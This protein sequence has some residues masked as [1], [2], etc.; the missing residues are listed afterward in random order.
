MGGEKID[1][2]Q[3]AC[4]LALVALLALAL[5]FPGTSGAEEE[6]GSVSVADWDRFFAFHYDYVL[7]ERA[8]LAREFEPVEVTLTTPGE[9]PDEWRDHVRVVRLV[10]G[11]RG[12]LTPHEVLGAVSA[13]AR[14]QGDSPVPAPAKSVNVV[15]LARC[16]AQG[17]VTYRLFWGLPEEDL[18]G[19]DSLPTANV[20][21][22]LA[23]SGE[24]PGLTIG[25]E[26]YTV[27][28]DARSG[29]IR[30]ASL[31]GPAKDPPMFYKSV[32]IHFGTD[33]WSPGQS[34]DHDYDWV[35]P[36]NQILEGG[37]LALRYHRWGPLEKYRDVVVSITYTFYAHVPYV[38]VSSVMEFTADRSARAVR[39]GEIVVSHSRTPDAE[40]AD[41]ESPDVFTHYA[42]PNDDGSTAICE[43]NAHR[44]QEG[45]ANIQGV[46]WG[47]LAILDRDV[48]WV[49]GYHADK[50]YGLAS[51]RNGQFAGNR[52]GGPVPASAPCTYVANYGWGFTY[53]S[54]PMVYPLGEK[55][56]SL[57]QNSAVA[58]G[59]IFATE[60]ALLF[61][62]PDDGL[63]GVSRA[64][65]KFA[66]PLRFCFRGTGPW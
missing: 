18:P 7:E 13:V 15:F 24:L 41:Q 53:W 60:E 56:T 1:M 33:I 61:F 37:I 8:G 36:P 20:E 5:A 27:Q 6:A 19:S 2:K 22:A 51:L 28:L 34:W 54:R 65:R 21:D 32:P 45:Q 23:V 46:A 11:N 26:F 57:D 17:K 50:A 12:V 47:A 43:V 38:R 35:R 66:E 63:R 3:L 39:M 42:W 48:P 16:P 44:D 4:G 25:N 62:E 55:G 59:T 40:G 58:A 9:M 31:A 49:A 30:T 52:L 29:A 10:E 14:A 64:Y